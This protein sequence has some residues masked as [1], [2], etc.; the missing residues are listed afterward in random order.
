MI[1]CGGSRRIRQ[2]GERAIPGVLSAEGG[3]PRVASDGE[4]PCRQVGLGEQAQRVTGELQEG[5]LQQIV[6][7]WQQMSTTY[8]GS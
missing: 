4:Q 6:G 7:Q 3:A 8:K 5:L 1:T 2:R